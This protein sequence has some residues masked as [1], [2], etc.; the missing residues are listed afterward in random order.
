MEEEKKVNWSSPES[1]YTKEIDYESIIDETQKLPFG[2]VPITWKDGTTTYSYKGKEYTNVNEIPAFIKGTKVSRYD[3]IDKAGEFAGNLIQSSPTLRTVLPPVAKGLSVLEAPGETSFAKMVGDSAENWGIDRRIGE[4][5]AYLAYPGLGELKPPAKFL[6]QLDDILVNPSYSKFDKNWAENRMLMSKSDDA[7]S[8]RIDATDL[9]DADKTAA[10]KKYYEQEAAIKKA[11]AQEPTVSRRNAKSNLNLYGTSPDIFEEFPTLRDAMQL[12]SQRGGRFVKVDN[13]YW[14]VFTRDNVQQVLPYNKWYQK[15]V[16]PFMVPKQLLKKLKKFEAGQGGKNPVT[17]QVP[18]G[19]Q[20]K[21]RTVTAPTKF[22]KGTVDEF[23]EWYKG[24]FRLQKAD[25]QLNRQLSKKLEEIGNIKAGNPGKKIFDSDLSHI[26][27]RSEGGSGLTF[28]EAWILNQQRGATDI[29][30]DKVLA[31]AGIP[32]NWEELFYFWY[33][34]KKPGRE[35]QTAIGPLSQINVDDYFALAK[36][37][38]LNVVGK[39]RKDIRNLINRQIGDP[40]TYSYPGKRGTIQD[41]FEAA[42]R[43]S[44]AGQVGGDIFFNEKLLD[45]RYAADNFEDLVEIGEI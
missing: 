42:V 13:K 37:E 16:N 18:F 31:A 29:L 34:Q 27:A 33:A 39:R 9:P 44:R 12:P 6:S 45:L 5:A 25:Q 7:L 30:D 28:Q 11:L 4:T 10:M 19:T 41:D 8:Q 1:G 32:K 15:H 21:F 35:L 14:T 22:P 17:L 2:V 23:N 38:P 3:W 40:D 36:G 43:A 26:K 24:V 20:G